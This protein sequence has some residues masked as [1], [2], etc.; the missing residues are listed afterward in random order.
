MPESLI[1]PLGY[2]RDQLEIARLQTANGILE[3]QVGKLKAISLGNQIIHDVDIAFVDNNLLGN[4]ILLGMNVL[5]QYRIIL[6]DEENQI[7]LIEK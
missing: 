6:D 7:T 1:T 2:A 3:A 4:V 5:S